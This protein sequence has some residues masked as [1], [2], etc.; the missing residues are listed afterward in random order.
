M[1]RIKGKKQKR[2]PPRP[3]RGRPHARGW[4]RERIDPV[5][6]ALAGLL[7]RLE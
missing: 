3:G 4:P 6:G 5:S 7:N 2:T 1:A